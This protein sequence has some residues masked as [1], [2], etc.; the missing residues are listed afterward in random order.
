[1]GN[2]FIVKG[3]EPLTGKNVSYTDA[4]GIYNYLYNSLEAGDTLVKTKG[5]ALFTIKKRRINVLVFYNCLDGIYRGN[6]ILDTLPKLTY[7]KMSVDTIL[8]E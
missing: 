1:M 8:K 5:N 3:L 6:G 2:S 4:D 7:G